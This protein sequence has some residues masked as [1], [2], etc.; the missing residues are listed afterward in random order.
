M[1]LEWAVAD[2]CISAADVF[3]LLHGVDPMASFRGRYTSRKQA[4]EIIKSEGG[5]FRLCQKMADETGL[6]SGPEQTGAIGISHKTNRG[7]TL[8][9][10]IQPGAWAG[11]TSTGFRVIKQAERAWHV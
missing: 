5:L 8:L 9:I 10:C 1:P 11:K 4:I 6:Q 2:C 3:D 7:R